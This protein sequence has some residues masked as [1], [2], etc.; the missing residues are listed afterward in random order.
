MT[1]P[2]HNE[3]APSIKS[4]AQGSREQLASRLQEAMRATKE[5]A[6]ASDVRVR[7][8]IGDMSPVVS[9]E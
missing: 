7:A 8:K 1:E 2:V 4:D 3:A 9:I 6:A 5:V